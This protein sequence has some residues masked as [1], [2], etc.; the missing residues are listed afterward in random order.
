MLNKR[1]MFQVLNPKGL[2][3]ISIGRKDVG[4]L[5][6]KNL[7]KSFEIIY[8][9]QPI[10]YAY[11][12]IERNV[13]EFETFFFRVS[14]PCN[15]LVSGI[16]NH[17]KAI[18]SLA[19]AQQRLTN[20]LSSANAF[21]NLAESKLK[22]NYGKESQLVSWNDFRRS[23]HKENI[24]YRLMYELRNY[25]LHYGLPVSSLK[26]D[27]NELSSD[28]PKK[29]VKINLSKIKILNSN[30]DW[31]NVKKDIDGLEESANLTELAF[32]Y[33]NIIKRLYLYL[34][35]IFAQ[36]LSASKNC[37]DVF[38]EKHNIPAEC[39]AQ[40]ALGWKDGDDLSNINCEILPI[41]ELKWILR[42]S[43]S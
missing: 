4:D 11:D 35:E 22:S 10:A 19:E 26:V 16:L 37:I 5:E 2:V 28:T 15:G 3:D 9:L 38:Y 27:M 23:L 8:F 39:T 32:E 12:S 36:E 14:D 31:K 24:S 17:M 7:Y 43:P 29:K 25:A 30:Y 21:L 41:N 33:A 6:L 40:I 20:L 34:L 13:T 42:L 1:I 18:S